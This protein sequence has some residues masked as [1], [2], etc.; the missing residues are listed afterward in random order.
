M[1]TPFLLTN[2]EPRIDAIAVLKEKIDRDFL[3]ALESLYPEKTPELEDSV[4][5][6][7]YASGQRSVVHLLRSIWLDG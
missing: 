3:D 6:I 5:K 4:D 2:V 1:A 7:R